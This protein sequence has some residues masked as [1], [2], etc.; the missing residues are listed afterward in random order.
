MSLKKY[1]ALAKTVELGSLSRAADALGYTQSGISHMISSLEE[2]LEIP[3]IIRKK[4]GVRLTAQGEQMLPKI[5]ELLTVNEEIER[6]AKELS[7]AI[8][9][10]VRVGAFTSVAVNWLPGIIKAFRS[11]CP[12]VRLAMFNGDYNDVDLWL[13]NDEI[14]VG[15]IA[16]PGPSGMTCIPLM[17]DPLAVI[18][19]QGHPLARRE[20]VPIEE[21]AKEPI[22]SLLQSSA[23]DVHRA[24]DSAGVKPDIRFTTKDD[25]AII[26]MVRE[27]LGISIMPELLLRGQVAGVEVRPLTP[28]SVRTLALAVTQK[29]MESEAVRRFTDCVARWVAEKRA[30][31]EKEG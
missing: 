24:L 13:Q 7:G 11:S 28:P 4:S 16:M 25:Y 8:H 12:E 22:I 26:A 27:G 3:L 6:L 23:Q 1:E 18:L 9:G 17:Q 19:P 15:F 30:E 10:T 5:K 29:G 20:S 2:E 14:D 21:A 31:E